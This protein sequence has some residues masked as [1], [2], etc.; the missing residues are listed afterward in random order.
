[1]IDKIYRPIRLASILIL[2]IL[3]FF[4]PI[5]CLNGE[6]TICLFKN[7]T[8]R[9][10]YGCGMTRAIISAIQFDFETAFH[11]NKLIVIVFP[12]LLYEWMKTIKVLFYEI[13]LKSSSDTH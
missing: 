12:L 11:Y 3:L 2:P 7:L 10:C 6:H 9:E 1:M 13:F 5:D 4:V 8:G